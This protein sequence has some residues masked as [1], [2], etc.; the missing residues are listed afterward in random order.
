MNL[1]TLDFETYYDDEYTLRK[2]TTEG[3]VRDPRF[4]TLGVAIRWHEYPDARL[5]QTMWYGGTRREIYDTLAQIDWSQTACLCHH[6]HF[7]GLILSHHFGFKPAFWLDTLP[8]ARTRLGNHLRVGLGALAE[9]YALAAKNVPYNAFKGKHWHELDPF[10]QRELGD[11][12]CHDCD[13]TRE[14]FTRLS[15]GFPADEYII[16]D[17]TIRMFTEPVLLGDVQK[18]GVIWQQEVQE[19]GQLL[20]ELNV[21]GAELR[22][23]AK[24]A[25]LLRAEG[26]EP[27]MKDGK[28]GETYA[29]AKTDDFMRELLDDAD[30]RVRTL[31]E[32]RLAE[33]STISQSRSERLGF[34]ATRGAL[35]VYLS[36][37]GA[38]TTRFSGGDKTNFQNNKRGHPIQGAIQAPPG[39]KCVINDASQIECRLLNF[40]ANQHDVIERFRNKEDPYVA[41]AS[42]FYGFE[43]TKANEAERGT[44]KQLELSCG[45]GAGTATIQATAKKGTYGPP[46]F[47]TTEQADYAKR[48]Y[49]Q[50]HPA[51]TAYWKEAGEVLDVLYEWGEREWGV[52]KVT[53]RHIVLP[54]GLFLNYDSIEW[55]YPDDT[56]KHGEWRLKT[57]KGWVKLYGAKVIENVIQALARVHVT[58]AWVRLRKA[59]L[60]MASMEHDKL[61]TV[62]KDEDKPYDVLALMR[63][64]MSRQ[65]DW[66]PGVPLDS[67]GFVSQSFAKEPKL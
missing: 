19:R 12:S 34:M 47:L 5:A 2:L 63:E 62:V 65:P 41:I 17:D 31:A 7:D 16:I 1:I 30:D 61:I 67:E 6:A 57:R 42:Q 33:R 39:S 14:I 37:G 9:H 44:G 58:D 38:H 21:V 49:R 53:D 55:Y 29:F 27:A 60:H 35:C 52:F 51:V 8:M 46:V 11:G 26:V 22:S 36:Y 50:T 20:L 43:V 28:R 13:L 23:D 18:L 3:Y 25:E 48:L 24:F 15:V 40:V 54:N 10:V 32:A 4:E 45:Y 59:G 56:P 64:E 66:L